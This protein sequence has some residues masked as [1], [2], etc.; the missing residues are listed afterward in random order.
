MTS[1][2]ASLFQDLTQMTI[3][4]QKGRMTPTITPKLGPKDDPKQGNVLKAA[5]HQMLS[6]SQA[7][8]QG[9]T[10]SLVPHLAGVE[11]DP[12]PMPETTTIAPRASEVPKLPGLTLLP[13]NREESLHNTKHRDEEPVACRNFKRIDS[14]T[15]VPGAIFEGM[16]KLGKEA[17]K[18]GAHRLVGKSGGKA[19]LRAS[20]AAPKRRPRTSSPIQEKR[21][22]STMQQWEKEQ[23]QHLIGRLN[24][25][26]IPAAREFQSARVTKTML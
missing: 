13:L 21:Q 22:P 25:I 1:H 10:S 18:R 20:N 7:P 11:E 16:M 6:H 14:Q 15:V 3:V 17:E 23:K 5:A 4:K 19:V 12:V 24:H 2:F 26:E 8:R 9:F